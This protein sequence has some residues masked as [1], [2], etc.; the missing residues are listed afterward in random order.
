M[1]QI[2]EQQLFPILEKQAEAQRD[3]IVCSWSPRQGLVGL[4]QVCDPP[5]PS[6]VP[7]TGTQELG[8]EKTILRT[9]CMM[10][11]VCSEH[12]WGHHL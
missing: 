3:S 11:I 8:L 1:K 9:M 7:P 4:G 2:L 5:L 10:C 12:V 6:P